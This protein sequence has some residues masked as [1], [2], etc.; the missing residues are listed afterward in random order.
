MMLIRPSSAYI[1][2]YLELVLNSPLITGIARDSTTGGAAPRV[3]V[4]TFKSYPIPV[5]PAEEQRWIVSK[6]DELTSLLNQLE[7]RLEAKFV[8]HKTF[9]AAAVHRLDV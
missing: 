1:A 5:P 4:S 7:Q 2:E 9:A 3:N 8:A 6:I